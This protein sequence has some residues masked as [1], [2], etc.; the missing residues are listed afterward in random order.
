M[1]IDAAEF[2]SILKQSMHETGVSV[3]PTKDMSP[4]D[5]AEWKRQNEK[6]KDKFKSASVSVADYEAELDKE[7]KFERGESVS[8]EE[9]PPELKE[10]VENPPPAVKKLREEMESK[11]AT[12]KEAA[13]LQARQIKILKDYLADHQGRFISWFDDLP[14]EVQSA[15][16]RV[17]D[18]ETLHMDVD[19]WLGDN[20]KTAAEQWIGWLKD[21]EGYLVKFFGPGAKASIKKIPTSDRAVSEAIDDSGGEWEDSSLEYAFGTRGRLSGK[22]ISDKEFSR[23]PAKDKK[24]LEGLIKGSDKTAAAW[25]EK[26]DSKGP[27]WEMK[28]KGDVIDAAQIREIPGPGIPLYL[29]Y[30]VMADGGVLKERKNFKSLSDAQKAA[31]AW[32][33]SDAQGASLIF[34]TF[35][36]V[37]STVEGSDKTAATGLYGFT[38]E[39]EKVCGSATNKLSKFTTKLAKD[40]YEKDSGTPAFLEEHTARTASK[41][42]R[43]LRGCMA[44]IGPGQPAKTAAKGEKGRYGFSAKTA[45]LALEACNAVEHEAGVIASDLDARMGTKYAAITGFLNKHAKRAKCGW[46]DLILEAYPAQSEQIIAS[47]EAVEK[48]ASDLSGYEVHPS[49][50]EILTWDGQ[51]TPRAAA[52]FLA[53]EDDDLI[54]GRTWDGDKSTPDDATPY[55]LHP[56]SPPAGADGSEQRWKYNQ[57]FRQNVCPGHKTNC[58]L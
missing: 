19:R 23:L 45:R 2:E 26:S 11:S 56:K 54:A 12:D 31:Q 41:A 49:V 15:L 17:K 27:F 58:G 30:L 51:G 42:A 25:A 53:S 22:S 16:V 47:E 40:I 34:Q 5:A 32:L 29:Q 14:Q 48:T 46:S 38:K 50:A 9:L 39:A 20:N 55:N 7:S 43:M 44:E 36:K 33:K 13:K 37:S 6:H 4:E 24:E 3:D 35:S 28:G 1:M 18:S 52:S 21:D 57:W 8:L 10:N